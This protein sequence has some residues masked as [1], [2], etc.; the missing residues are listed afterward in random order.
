MQVQIY[1]Y[2]NDEKPWQWEVTLGG[3][4]LGREYTTRR[5]CV[6]GLWRWAESVERELLG[7]PSSGHLDYFYTIV[8]DAIRESRRGK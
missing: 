5:A 2:L 6:R 1:E 7:F 3:L 4:T 8:Y